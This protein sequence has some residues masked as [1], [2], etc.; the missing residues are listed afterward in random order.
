MQ[1]DPL[2]LLLLIAVSTCIIKLWRDDYRAARAGRP[3]PRPLPGATRAPAR[4]SVVAAAGALV[5]LAVE[6]GG[7]HALG[8]TA[9]QSRMTALFALYTLCAAFVEEIIFRGFIVIDKRGPAALWA[10]AAGA[11][12]LFAALHPF[13]WTW[14]GGWPWSGGALE[15]NFG[16]KGWFSTACAFAGSLW[17]YAMRFAPLNPDRSLLPCFA[18]HCA[19]NLGVIGVK[20]AQG[21]LGGWW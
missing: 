7:E 5:L 12:F 2:L 14:T 15:W 13:L 8:L 21:F 10:G 1:N 6:T 18:G 19:K 16:A 4:A 9:E 11:S 3:A 20:A 17:F